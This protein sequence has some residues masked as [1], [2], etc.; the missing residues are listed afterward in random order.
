MLFWGIRT[1]YL[2]Q[3]DFIACVPLP[4]NRLTTYYLLVEKS[5]LENCWKTRFLQIF[6]S[7]LKGHTRSADIS[8]HRDIFVQMSKIDIYHNENLF[9]SI[10]LWRVIIVRIEFSHDLTNIELFPQNHST[11]LAKLVKIPF[12]TSKNFIF[13][14]KNDIGLKSGKR[15]GLSIPN[16]I[17]SIWHI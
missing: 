13:F 17:F 11:D 12:W 4:W 16:N 9:R 2:A 3:M 5:M 10:E 8:P 1:R 15:Y 6:H 7:H 14:R